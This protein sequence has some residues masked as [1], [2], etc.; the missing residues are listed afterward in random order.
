MTRDW[1]IHELVARTGIKRR[2]IRYLIEHD[3]VAASGLRQTGGRPQLTFTTDEAVVAVAASHAHS[4]IRL[5]LLRPLVAALSQELQKPRPFPL[6]SVRIQ[7]V[8]YAW[9]S[10]NIRAIR[11]SLQD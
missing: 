5:S 10:F 2:I 6:V 4:S 3:V 1:T 8:Q 11:A 7:V 9:F